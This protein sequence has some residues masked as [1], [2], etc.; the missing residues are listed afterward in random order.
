MRTQPSPISGRH[1]AVLVLC[2][3]LLGAASVL[4]GH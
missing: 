4:I 1:L 3:L 2:A